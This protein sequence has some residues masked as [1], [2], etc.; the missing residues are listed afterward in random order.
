VAKRIKTRWIVLISVVVLLI[1]ARIL[2]PYALVRI[3]NGKL[4]DLN[5]YEGTIEDID[6]NLYRGAYVIESVSIVKTGDSIPV[7]FVAVEKI[8]IAIQW[9][10]LFHGR[11]VARIRLTA[12]KLNF[13][14]AEG[15]DG[16]VTQDGK[17]VNWVKQFEGM[18]PLRINRVEINDGEIVYQD[19]TTD[20]QVNVKIDNFDVLVTN[21]S[22]IEDKAEALPS[23][24]KA[25]GEVYEDG[26]FNLEARLNILREIP[27][28]DLNMEIEGVE[29][30]QLNDFLR[31]YTN[32]DAEAGTFSLYTEIVIKDASVDGY[33]KPVLENVS[34]LEWKQ[35]E[36]P[37]F[38]KLWEALVAGVVELFEN[39]PEDRV[40][41]SVPLSGELK[42]PDVDAFTAIWNIFKNAFIDAISKQIDNSIDFKN[43]NANQ[44]SN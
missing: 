30:T 17:G 12:P 18:W 26:S 7:P 36:E 8:D 4:A 32:T 6:L 9:N 27:D 31:A 23:A 1:I 42:D 37:F 35:E 29:L 22:N 41:T 20:P 11:I 25:T 28:I 16:N 24:L 5:G 39:Q 34:I 44:S 21:L 38:N 33:V 14:V 43:F 3:A 40:A 10:A 2:L 19:F 13:A 15:E